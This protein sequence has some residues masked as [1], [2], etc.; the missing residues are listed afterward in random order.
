M[1]DPSPDMPPAGASTSSEGIEPGR[2]RGSL[3]ARGFRL[4][5]QLALT[6]VVTWFI[7]K[8]VDFSLRELGGFD[9]SGLSVNWVQMVASGLVLLSAYLFSAG[10][11]GLMVREMSGHEVGFLPSLRVF[12]TANLGR[13][14]PGKLWQIAGLAYL[15]KG[16]GVPAGTATGAAV[17]G[18]AFSLAGATL[19]GGGV[20]LGSGGGSALG[21][22]WVALILLALLLTATS[23]GLLKALVPLWFRVS[24]QAAPPSFRPD[25]AFGIRWMG[26]YALTWSLQGLGFWILVGS[27]GFDL[28]LLEGVPAYP[29]AY[30]A[31]YL[32]LFAPAG[33][34]IREG[35]LIVLLGPALGVGAGVVA[36]VARLWATAVELIPAAVLAGGY[37]R[38][39]N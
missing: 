39:S 7:L 6:V 18:Q 27:L 38:S 26:L 8:S 24:R 15:A 5:L 16:Q 34:G 1:T 20:L 21:G 22:G 14:I 25:P 12:F 30:V 17:L 9:I 29:A 13:Y 3:G 28:T 10:L 19:V 11:W 2:P 33:A 23:P 32:A 37:M 35:L 4:A 36:I 31:G